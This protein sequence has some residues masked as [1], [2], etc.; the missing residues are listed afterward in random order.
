[1]AALLQQPT[2]QAP[3]FGTW[4]LDSSRAQPN[5]LSP[6]KRVTMKIQPWEDGLK[7]VYDMVGT[8]GGVFHIEW[9]GRFD[10]KDYTVQGVDNVLT[11]AYTLTNSGYSIV[12]KADG[13][14]VSTAEVTVSPDGKTMTSVTSQRTASG[15]E[16][17]TTA[18][19]ARR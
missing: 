19:Y 8:R 15:A 3:W 7:V 10:G 1:M 2:Q 5:T 12:V 13:K 4:T 17:R 18:V 9:T 16:S 11:N 6:Y 14:P